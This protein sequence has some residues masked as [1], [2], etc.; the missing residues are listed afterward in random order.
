MDILK[1][2]AFCITVIRLGEPLSINNN[3]DHVIQKSFPYLR[4]HT[5]I[6]SPYLQRSNSIWRISFYA[7]GKS[8]NLSL[9]KDASFA[10]TTSL[11]VNGKVLSD[12]QSEK[13]MNDSLLV[14][15]CDSRFPYS[16]YAHGK[17]YNNT[18]D[19]FVSYRDETIFIEPL[20]SHVPDFTGKSIVYKQ[21]D[22]AEN[23]P[24]S[25]I[26]FLDTKY[27]KEWT[28]TPAYLSDD[29]QTN[30]Y[31]NYS[32]GMRTHYISKRASN[33][34]SRACSLHVFAV[35][36]FY[37]HIGDFSLSKTIT[38]MRYQVSQADMIFRGTD[39]SGD[40]Y[41]DN[42]GFE[43]SNFTVFTR[44]TYKMA[45]QTLSVNDYLSS[46]SEYDF[47]QFCLAVA[48]T[49]RDFDGGVVGLAWTA[50]SSAYGSPGGLC[51][52]RI[53]ALDG[54]MRS[55]NTA[56]VTMLNYGTRISSYKS[57]LVLTHEFGH[58]FGSSHDSTSDP[59]CTSNTHGNFI[60]YAYASEGSNPNENKFSSC[61]IN[62]M[63]PVIVNK[64]SCLA[65]RSTPFCGNGI[66]EPGEECDC[67]TSFS[68]VYTDHCCTPADVT[69]SS[70]APCT[71]RL[72]EGKVCSPKTEMCCEQN[73]T[74]T[75]ANVQK[76]CGVSSECQESPV[77]NG[78][79]SACP[80]PISKP[81]NLSCDS[82]RKFCYNGTCSKSACEKGNLAECQ[83]T[84]G[85][86]NNCKLCCKGYNTSLCKPANEFGILSVSGNVIMLASG[87]SCNGFK[88]FCNAQHTCVSED[89]GDVID[90][91]KNAFSAEVGQDIGMWMKNNW[92]YIFFGILSFFML[93]LLFIGCRRKNENVQGRA[94]R[95]GR[96]EQVLAQ[97]RL[98]K[99]KQEKK[100]AVMAALFDKRIRKVQHGHE[101]LEYTYAVVRLSIFFPTASKA[102]I[103]EALA[104]CSSEDVA[105]RYLLVSGYPMRKMI[106][107]N[108][109]MIT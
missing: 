98:E 46:F 78:Y 48:F 72:S 58:N 107:A 86:P 61:S 62:M 97:A 95:Q 69:N 92:Y 9:F 103:R 90:R 56:L 20:E 59:L 16:S 68:C 23:F 35:H 102:V 29:I 54:K 22:I 67:G 89:P 93:I 70:D 38:E 81:D 8:I 17:I 82:E 63:Y 76:V 5:I 25:R 79:D 30:H 53:M 11:K 109:L 21:S 41:G 87:S 43:I 3:Q 15:G 101:S 13:I 51:Q 66:I 1:G 33:P 73:C 12:S 105:V 74:L 31:A 77:C 14:K 106:C 91:L 83:C 40:G 55:Y 18:Y 36:N 6:P 80:F 104:K 27:A 26:D 19:G 44:P 65:D 34:S 37:E 60:M 84:S 108:D 28:E 96:F 39:F 88:G 99:E 10:F 94:Y 45:D 4:N 85:S 49:Y 42:I 2:F 75:P 50:S 47:D 32:E 100:M 7:F 64:G 71:Y 57:S 52:R 24:P